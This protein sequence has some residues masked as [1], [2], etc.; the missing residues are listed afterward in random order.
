LNFNLKLVEVALLWLLEVKIEAKDIFETGKGI[1]VKL[2]WK[3]ADCSSS[4]VT[5]QLELELIQTHMAQKP[6]MRVV[7]FARCVARE[8]NRKE[9]GLLKY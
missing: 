9:V 1:H 3:M 8:S 5:I 6:I 4:Y 2:S 7:V